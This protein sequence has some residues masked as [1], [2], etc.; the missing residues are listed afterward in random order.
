MRL[1][2]LGG[3]GTVTGS[4]YLLEAGGLRLLV[5]CGL[6][7]GKDE[8]LNRKPMPLAPYGLDGVILTHAHID[9]SGR[10]PL[11]RRQG[12]SGPIYAHNA[13]ADLAAIMLLDSAHIQEMEAERL[14]RK[15]RRAGRDMVQPLYSADD[16]HRVTEQFHALPYGKLLSLSPSL[17]IRLQ[18][19]GHILG[20]AIVEVFETGP[21]G[22]QAKLVLSGDLGRPDRPI[23]RDPTVIAEA[24]FLV[25]ESTYGNR[26][27]EP[28]QSTRETFATIIRSTVAKGGKVIIPAFAVGRTQEV[29]YQLNSLVEEGQLPRNLRV[30]LD[31]PLAIAATEVTAK[32]RDV[33][34]EAARALV[35]SGDDPFAFPGLVLSHTGDDSRALNENREPMVIVAAGG[36]CE[37]GRV[38]HH[39]KHNLWRHTS[40]VLFV[41]YQAEGTLG[42]RILEGASRVRIHGE[43]VAVNCR[44]ESL[45]GLSAHA[46][47]AQLLAWVDGFQ[48]APRQTVLVHGEAEAREEL[49]RLLMLRGHRVAMPLMDE[50]IELAPGV[51]RP[52]VRRSQTAPRDPARVALAQGSALGL[53]SQRMSAL[54][55][56]LR[57]L[58]KAWH[59]NGPHLPAGQ[60]EELARRAA[61]LQQYLEAMRR[62]IEASGE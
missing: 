10:L 8:E 54:L 56:E 60:A 35:R 49:A 23:L 29:L 22:R 38:V 40:T 46:D 21:D 7:Q 31:S 25:M 52:A 50:T 5:D 1:T 53:T 26:L 4:S 14:T 13:T 41:G 44:I 55:K 12:F 28:P 16:A 9:H 3:A 43:D 58:K 17:Q 47:Q 45:Q 11:L 62:L 34:D 61:E 42:R 20:S 24:D 2:F 32:H 19:A 6:F 57:A 30:V 39:L 18:D 33:Y 37:N 15:A 48:Q 59:A 51:S 36:M 27:H